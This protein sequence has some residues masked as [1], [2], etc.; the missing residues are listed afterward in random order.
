MGPVSIPRAAVPPPSGAWVVHRWSGGEYSF[1][2]ELAEVIE[3]IEPNILRA[4][5][6]QAQ[7]EGALKNAALGR[8]R[9]KDENDEMSIKRSQSQPIIWEIPREVVRH[10]V[11]LYVSEPTSGPV[12]IV[13]LL[14]HIKDINELTPD[15]IRQRQNMKMKLAAERYVNYKSVNWGHR[16]RM[17]PGCIAL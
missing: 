3:K 13:A 15:E 2:Q 17:C 16:R 4:G 5:D 6:L 12:D 9:V 7:I 8:L 11:R 14:V 1:S 10:E